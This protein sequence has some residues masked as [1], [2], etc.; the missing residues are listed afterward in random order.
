MT[1][2]G[3]AVHLLVNRL[4]LAYPFSTSSEFILLSFVLYFLVST[5]SLDPDK[6]KFEKSVDDRILIQTQEECQT[7]H[8]ATVVP[9]GGLAHA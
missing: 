1:S 5:E 9:A 2:R 7:H 4:V 3:K 6:N 8:H